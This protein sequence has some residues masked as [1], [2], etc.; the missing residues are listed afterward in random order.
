MCSTGNLCLVPLSRNWLGTAPHDPLDAGAAL[1][2]LPGG[3]PAS[4][5]EVLAGSAVG[6]AL[7]ATHARGAVVAGCSA[8]A[9]V[10]AGH[11][12]DPR[13]RIV[14]WPLRWRAGLRFVEDGAL[15]GPE[16]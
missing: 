14:P 11:L 6:R 2:Y 3:K 5:A 8:G 1:V 15:V 4:L 12:F 13:G 7:A 16:P 9:M 10:L